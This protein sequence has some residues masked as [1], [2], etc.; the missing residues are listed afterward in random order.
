MAT[1]KV[2][3]QDHP[4]TLLVCPACIA[5]EGGLATAKKY[6]T[7]QLQAWGRK[8]GRPRKKKKAKQKKEKS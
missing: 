4:E 7:K 3:C 1:Q 2:Y 8:G 6:G 5:K